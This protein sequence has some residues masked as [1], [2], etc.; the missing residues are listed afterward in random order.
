MM[1]S[2]LSYLRVFHFYP[3]L[4]FKSELPSI[5]ETAQKLPELCSET[6]PGVATVPTISREMLFA[7]KEERLKEVEDGAAYQVARRP[8]L[9][10]SQRPTGDSEEKHGWDGEAPQGFEKRRMWICS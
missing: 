7:Q 6:D 10:A 2:Q 9:E 8:A 3:F 5:R 1:V 4:S